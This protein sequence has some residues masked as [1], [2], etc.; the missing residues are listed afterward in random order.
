MA[1]LCH[2]LMRH[3]L[4]LSTQQSR[5]GWCPLRIGC[6]R[7]CLVVGS[8]WR[9][10]CYVH[11]PKEQMERQVI[12]VNVKWNGIIVEAAYYQRRHIQEAVWRNWTSK[13]ATRLTM[14]NGFAQFLF[15]W[16]HEGEGNT[17]CPYKHVCMDGCGWC[18]CVCARARA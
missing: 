5:G 16:V 7:K 2:L 10:P 8:L 12:S 18:V 11:R 13:Q 4:S 17:V 14:P 1:P 9:H 6:R 3:I 15:F